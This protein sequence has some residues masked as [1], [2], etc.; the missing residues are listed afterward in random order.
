MDVTL[1][2]P[3]GGDA[4][5]LSPWTIHQLF[6]PPSGTNPYFY[7]ILMRRRAET[8]GREEVEPSRTPSYQVVRSSIVSVLTVSA[9]RRHSRPFQRPRLPVR[10]S[11][12]LTLDASPIETRP[13]SK[14]LDLCVQILVP[15]SEVPCNN[16][17]GWTAKRTADCP[18]SSIPA[19]GS[20]PASQSLWDAVDVSD[21]QPS[22]GTC[23]QRRIAKLLS[24]FERRCDISSLCCH[25]PA[26]STFD[27]A[28]GG[29]TSHP[30]HPPSPPPEVGSPSHREPAPPF[31]VR[32]PREDE[33]KN[34]LAS[35][36]Q[37]SSF[38]FQP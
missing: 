20:S 38:A 35:E 32:P 34:I 27:P 33:C 23:P 3:S 14:D 9:S 1:A 18:H 28:G 29:G 13:A 10:I 17:G 7:L 15:L 5:G 30:T 22:V 16:S 12:P 2:P 6:P 37:T 11:Q 21:G 19:A 36:P 31:Q 24:V 8:P 25:I 26:A 4:A